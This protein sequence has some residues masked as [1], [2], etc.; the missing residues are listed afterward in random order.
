MTKY[1]VKRILTLIPVLLIVSIVIFLLIH[2][3]PGDP[4]AAM[5]GDLATPEEVAALRERMGLNKPLPV[6]YWNW[7][8]RVLHGDLGRSMFIEGSMLQILGARL[9]PTIQLTVVSVLLAALVSVPLGMIAA[10]K[11]NTPLDQAISAVSILNVSLPGFLV[12][13]ALMYLFALKLKLLP[14]AGYRSIA[15]YGWKMHIQYMIAPAV[16]LGLSESALMIRHTRSSMLEILN[17]DYMRMAKAKGIS[18][19]KMFAKHG[20][21]NAAIGVVTVVGLAFMTLLGG[22]T[23]IETIFNIP[24][25]GQ[26]T[27]VSVTRR[28]YEVVQAVVL[29]ISTTNVL[30]MLIMDLI[31][32]MLDPRIRLAD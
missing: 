13:V 23:I 28:D 29:L 22:A 14:S 30:I 24:G 8:M 6:Q 15:E 10:V 12:A 3:T 20:L 19:F 5:L 7:L 31:Y 17:S 21:K 9:V 32:A 4:A 1:L 2:M 11:R 16:A 18:S 25:I 27:I 26:L